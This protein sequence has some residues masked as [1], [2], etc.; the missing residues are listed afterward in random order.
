[1]NSQTPVLALISL[2]SVTTTLSLV[3]APPTQK[4]NIGSPIGPLKLD[5]FS[6]PPAKTA[7]QPMIVEFWATWCG[8]CVKTIPHLNDL[9]AKY[10]SKGLVIIGVTDENKATVNKFTAKHPMNYSVASDPS[11]QLPKRLG[12]RSIPF[13][14]LVDSTGQIVWEGHPMSLPETEIQRILASATPVP[15][16]GTAP[17]SPTPAGKYPPVLPVQPGPRPG[18]Y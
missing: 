1:M 5:Y 4:T 18:W 17:S 14:V 12:V 9:Y 7:G 13:A 10:H 16:T 3:A 2:L 8:P 6:N 15:S 11:S